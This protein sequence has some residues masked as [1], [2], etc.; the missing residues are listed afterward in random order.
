M[1][2]E[3]PS[4]NNFP[5]PE[6]PWETRNA[7]REAQPGPEGVTLPGFSLPPS[8]PAFGQ[9]PLPLQQEAEPT[10]SIDF[11]I[12]TPSAFYDDID[13]SGIIPPH[14]LET[15]GVSSQISE[16]KYVP[17]EL[18]KS[19]TVFKNSVAA[20]L[21]EAGDD[22]RAATLEHCHSE[23]I[24][25]EC[26]NCRKTKAY[27]NHCDNF[28]C[29][30]CQPRLSRKR[31]EGLQWWVTRLSR[32][33][34]VTLTIKNTKH[35]SKYDVKQIKNDFQRLRR[36]V[37][38]RGW[39]GGI[40][41]VEVTNEGRGW[42]LHL[43]SLVDA[44]WIDARELAVTW[45]KITA[46]RGFIV[47]VKDA[48]RH[49]YLKEVS[50]YCCKGSE[51]AKWSSPEILEFITAFTGVKTFGVFGNLYGKRTEW[52]EWIAHLKESRSACEC[53]CNK[54]RF[55]DENEWQAKFCHPFTTGSPAPPV[56]PA[57]FS[58]AYL[59]DASAKNFYALAR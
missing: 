50:K 40:Y 24:R 14:Q 45:G 34:F 43:H 39:K 35:L 42:H 7:E 36:S 8:P 21:R 55:Y 46:G 6:R 49:G 13:V 23:L 48:S 17:S 3:Q 59:E 9:S 56:L 4:A 37:F 18:W 32:A 41:S 29:P 31:Q 53:G 51:I 12:D 58:F 30:E 2:A 57:Q 5:G 15:T 10:D 19:Q 47:K 38:A 22:E 20:K 28:W 27:R 44:G 11:D 25:A 16:S 54:F 1:S 26:T 52:S 33:K